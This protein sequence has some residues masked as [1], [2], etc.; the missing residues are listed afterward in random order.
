MSDTVKKVTVTDHSAMTVKQKYATSRMEGKGSKA[1]NKSTIVTALN[2]RLAK[3]PK[4][5]VCPDCGAPLIVS[6]TF[7]IDVCPV[8]PFFSMH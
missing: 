7:G 3:R 1:D 8:C 2:V 4:G 6:N 5:G